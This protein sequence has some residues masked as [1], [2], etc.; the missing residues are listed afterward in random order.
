MVDVERH[1]VAYHVP[2]GG[3]A[4]VL[5]IVFRWSMVRRSRGHFPALGR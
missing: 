5:K 3:V 2:Y 1:H 4:T